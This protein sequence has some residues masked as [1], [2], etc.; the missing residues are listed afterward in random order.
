MAYKN[1]EKQKQYMKQWKINN[2]EYYRRLGEYYRQYRLMNKEKIK[3]YEK[4]WDIKNK[5]HIKTI[6]ETMED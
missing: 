4:Q 3:E 1:K 6:Y 2:R 5:E